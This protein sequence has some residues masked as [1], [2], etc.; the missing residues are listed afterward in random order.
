MRAGRENVGAERSQVARDSKDQEE[1]VTRRK[2]GL[3]QSW[4]RSQKEGASISCR[5]TRALGSC[6]CC[7]A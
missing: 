2:S 4:G 6:V 3:G 5:Q 7:A 1:E